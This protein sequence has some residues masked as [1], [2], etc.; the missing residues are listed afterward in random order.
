MHETELN[1]IGKR[2]KEIRMSKELKLIEVAEKA[3]ISKG[4]L[5]KVENA[6]TVPSIP[7]LFS[8]IAALGENPASFF[9]S[10]KLLKGEPLYIVIRK[11]DYKPEI[12]EDSVGFHYFSV[13]S[14]VFTNTLFKVSYLELDPDARR[15]LVSTDGMEF[16]Y[17]IEGQINYRL[18]DDSLILY[19][20]DSLFF[21]GRVPHVKLNPYSKTAR[22]LVIYLLFNNN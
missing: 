1:Q 16:I 11:S 21:D 20:G 13:F 10:M 22:I 18:G 4:L 12:K 5:S 14:Q 19:E 7:V 9:E 6:R 8:L 3:G 17:L 15:D 2:I